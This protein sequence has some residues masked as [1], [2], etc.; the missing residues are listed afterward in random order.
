MADPRGRARALPAAL[1]ERLQRPPLPAR[2]A[3]RRRLHAGGRRPGAAGRARR[4]PVAADLTGRAVRRGGGLR[5]LSAGDGGDRGQ[6]AGAGPRAER[7][8]LPGHRP[9]TAGRR[10]AVPR[11]LSA[12]PRAERR[13]AAATRVFDFRRTGEG[14]HEAWTINGLPFRPGRPLAAPRLGTTEVWRL[15]SD[16]H[17]PVHVHLAHFLVLSRGGRSAGPADAGW[18]D[19]VDVR[20]YEVVEVL[21]RFEGY[22][23]R[24]MM[25]CHNLEHEDMAMMADF[26]VV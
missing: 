7:A 12:P 11:R 13:A 3:A 2:T 10:P 16:F 8:A 18:K 15:A 9:G 1:A 17:H 24:Y 20:P 25:H 26:E 6:H 19:T 14:A 21:V 23:G 22:R 4:A 5:R